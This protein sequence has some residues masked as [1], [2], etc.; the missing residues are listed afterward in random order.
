MIGI[1][2]IGQGR[3]S[4][5]ERINRNLARQNGKDDQKQSEKA[6][7]TDVFTL[8]PQGKKNSLVQNLMKQKSD[9]TEQKNS[10]I[11][12]TIKNGGS[13]DSVKSQLEYYDEQVKNLDTQISEMMAQEME[14][15]T[16]KEEKQP[17][18][19]LKTKEEVQNERLFDIAEIS[20]DVKQS[21]VIDAVKSTIERDAKV[22][23][24]EI[25][26]DRGSSS[27]SPIQKKEE[28]LADLEQR[29]LDLTAQV[30]EKLLNVV[31]NANNINQPQQTASDEKAEDKKENV[32]TIKNLYI[33]ED[34]T[35][36]QPKRLNI[37]A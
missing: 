36:F 9:I 15:Q 11:S 21:E 28:A 13:L 27:S 20:S 30:G 23:S 32:A 18:D 3:I 19:E 6:G 1:F 16:Q 29:A 37:T 25:Q 5:V 7:R 12:S 4:S 8:S 33:T 35:D 22:L 2:G 17:D 24:S 26:M 14:K 34:K 10:L 31:E